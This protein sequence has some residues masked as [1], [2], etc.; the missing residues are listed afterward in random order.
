MS[1]AEEMPQVIRIHK[2]LINRLLA[3][4]HHLRQRPDAAVRVGGDEDGHRDSVVA[5]ISAD[6]VLGGLVLAVAE[7]LEGVADVDDQSAVDRRDVD[8]GVGVEFPDVE[9]ADVVLEEHGYGGDVG[10]AA[11]AD[12]E[13]RVGTFGVVVE[14]YPL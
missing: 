1:L 10:V 9:A 3:A 7:D 13:L 14:V 4:L 6:A 11:D 8:P 5:A 12:G 2:L